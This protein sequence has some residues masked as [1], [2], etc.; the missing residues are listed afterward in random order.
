MPP[1]TARYVESDPIGSFVNKSR[2][3]RVKRE[4]RTPLSLLSSPFVL[5]DF[6]F[7][8]NVRDCGPNMKKKRKLARFVI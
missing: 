6:V 5:S 7:V 2:I 8:S 1:W 4:N 3:L